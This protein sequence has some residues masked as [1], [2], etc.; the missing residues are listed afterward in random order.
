MDEVD[1]VNMKVREW[2]ETRDDPPGDRFSDQAG[3]VSPTSFELFLRR[4]PFRI[5]H[6]VFSAPKFDMR[7]YEREE[8]AAVARRKF[9]HLFPTYVRTTI[10]EQNR[11]DFFNRGVPY[12]FM[13]LCNTLKGFN[14]VSFLLRVAKGQ[15]LFN[16]VDSGVP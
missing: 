1:E 16:L 5:V 11:Q 12:S 8:Y 14:T 15:S 2:F 9:P 4:N 6:R 7:L 10:D 13:R 3:N